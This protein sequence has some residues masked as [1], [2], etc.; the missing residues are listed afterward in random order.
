MENGLVWIDFKKLKLIFR[1]AYDLFFALFYFILNK[2]SINS[3]KFWQNLGE[4][5]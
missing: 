5:P 4:E 2:N 1:R 3:F